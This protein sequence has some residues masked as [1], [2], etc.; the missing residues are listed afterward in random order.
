MK[1]KKID[2]LNAP[3]IRFNVELDDLTK[4]KRASNAL[5]KSIYSHITLKVKVFILSEAIQEKN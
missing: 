3:N 1:N 5:L 4:L 2:A